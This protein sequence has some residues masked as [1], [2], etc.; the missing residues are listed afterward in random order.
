MRARQSEWLMGGRANIVADG[1]QRAYDANIQRVRAEVEAEYDSE[2]KNAGL[3]Q[4]VLL[5]L[6][7]EWETQKR[8]KKIAPS[9]GLY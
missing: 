1:Q 3:W 2:M 9:D 5:Q 7:V 4:A 8:M 6:T